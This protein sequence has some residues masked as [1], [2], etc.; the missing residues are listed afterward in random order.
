MNLGPIFFTG[1]HNYSPPVRQ[2][3]WSKNRNGRTLRLGKWGFHLWWIFEKAK[4]IRSLS[5]SQGE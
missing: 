4:R 5:T 3:R 1:V 2:K